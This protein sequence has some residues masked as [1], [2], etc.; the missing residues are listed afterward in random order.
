MEQ[1]L[2]EQWRVKVCNSSSNL[3]PLPTT[4]WTTL[5][6][7]NIGYLVNE[8]IKQRADHFV[9]YG[10]SR[11]GKGQQAVE[12]RR[13]QSFL[14]RLNTARS[15]ARTLVIGPT[16]L[17]ISFN[18]RIFNLDFI[19]NECLVCGRM[20]APAQTRLEDFDEDFGMQNYGHFRTC[21]CGDR[22]A[23]QIDGHRRP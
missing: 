9:K 8:A 20:S 6:V 11:F 18:Y 19:C 23:Y 7:P 13:L 12:F 21:A 15:G 3:S 16:E 2:D 1:K 4:H 14:K 17:P 10:G 22:I 5:T